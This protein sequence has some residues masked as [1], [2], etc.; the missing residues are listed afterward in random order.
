MG[1]AVFQRKRWHVFC[2]N[3]VQQLPAMWRRWWRKLILTKMETSTTRKW[4]IGFAELHI[5]RSTSKQL[6]T[7]SL[8][9][10][11]KWTKTSQ[12]WKRWEIWLKEDF[13][14]WKKEKKT[15]AKWWR[16]FRSLP[17]SYRH[18]LTRPWL[19]W[20]SSLSTTMIRTTVV[21]WAMM[22]A[23]YSLPILLHYVIHT[24]TAFHSWVPARV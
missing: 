16:S 1:M 13:M 12:A 22:R 18:V 17:R 21:R 6:T 3:Y 24:C 4:F 19:H 11:E 14:I 5:L 23:S 20:S 8:P 2:A 10:S 9:T 7:C 15:L